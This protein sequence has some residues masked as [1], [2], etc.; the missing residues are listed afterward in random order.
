MRKIF[1]VLCI[2]VLM[3]AGCSSAEETSDNAQKNIENDK[4]S[5]EI[6]I[7]DIYLEE[8]DCVVDK[9]LFWTNVTV[10]ILETGETKNYY[11]CMDLEGNINT[12]IEVKDGYE[13]YK[14]ISSE[15]IALQNNVGQIIIV[16]KYNDITSDFCTGNEYIKF[17][18]EDDTGITI[19]V[20]EDIE[21]FEK[22]ES[23]IK[24]LNEN[25][26]IKFASSTEKLKESYGLTWCEFENMRY[27]GGTTYELNE[28]GMISDFDNNIHKTF[29]L[30]LDIESNS[31]ME[32]TVS[33]TMIGHGATSDGTYTMYSIENSV[34]IWDKNGNFTFDSRNT[35]WVDAE[36]SIEDGLFYA[37]ISTGWNKEYCMMNYKGEIVFRLDGVR[38]NPCYHNESAPISMISAN[39]DG[40]PYTTFI[41]TSGNWLFEPVEGDFKNYIE[42]IEMCTVLQEDNYIVFLDKTGKKWCK[43]DGIS[44]YAKKENHYYYTFLEN[45]KLNIVEFVEK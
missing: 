29:D 11:A 5:E 8:I 19:W 24:A 36:S 20:Q 26:S 2:I 13:F 42:S 37:D 23:L 17:I 41:D 28:G 7:N 14:G 35:G 38:N 6:Y 3:F 45:G 27:I 9:E 30:Y 1:I 15:K 4:Y 10:S 44:F 31:I 18:Q 22:N 21:T 40:I 33:N 39:G 32:I 34:Y 16:N 12:K 43:Y 25:G